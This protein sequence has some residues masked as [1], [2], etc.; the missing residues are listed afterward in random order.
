MNSISLAE[1]EQ[2]RNR[3][4]ESTLRSPLVHLGVDDTP[5]DIYLKLE[6]LQPTGSFK[7]RGA[8]NAI[9]L[10]SSHE[11][12]R[13]CIL[14]ARETWRRLSHGMRVGSESPVPQ[15]YLTL[16]RKRNCRR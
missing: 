6:N 3:I 10:L 14:V 7:V 13:G 16:L 1:I 4:A 5:A 11:R 12:D 15:S 2:A 9:A 8:A